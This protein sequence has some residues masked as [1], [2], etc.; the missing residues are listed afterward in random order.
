MYLF[1]S[2]RTLWVVVGELRFKCDN[3]VKLFVD[4]KALCRHSYFG[5]IMLSSLIIPDPEHM[6]ISQLWERKGSNKYY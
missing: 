2:H 4:Y 6:W 3:A 5:Y 1:L